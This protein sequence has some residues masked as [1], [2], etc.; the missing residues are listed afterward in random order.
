MGP[1]KQCQVGGR[2]ALVLLGMARYRS[3]C[4]RRGE[5]KPLRTCFIRTA[6][7]V[8]RQC[9]TGLHEPLLNLG[10]FRIIAGDFGRTCR[11]ILQDG[12]AETK[13]NAE[14]GP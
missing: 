7:A 12:S 6:T 5:G 4:G 3:L 1:L 11:A 10:I 9:R 2:T 8:A 14:N 13:P